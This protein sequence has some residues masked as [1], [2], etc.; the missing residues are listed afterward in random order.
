MLRVCY[1]ITTN[2]EGKAKMSKINFAAL[3]GN[4]QQMIETLSLLRQSA[5]ATMRI[6]QNRRDWVLFK[7]AQVNLE[8]ISYELSKYS[9]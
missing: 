6:A 9:K 8:E 4:D 2:K 7:K 1:C 3:K 5:V